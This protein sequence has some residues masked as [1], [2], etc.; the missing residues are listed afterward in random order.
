[1]K[2]QLCMRGR[3]ADIWGGNGGKRLRRAIGAGVLFLLLGAGALSVSAEVTEGRPGETLS[4]DYAVIVNTSMTDAQSTGT[5]VFDAS[6]NGTST[7]RAAAVQDTVGQDVQADALRPALRSAAYGAAYSVGAQKSIDSPYN[8]RRTYVCIGE[9]AHCYV[10]MEE[11][12]KTGYDGLKKTDSIANDMMQT[13]EGQPY[14]MLKEMAGGSLPWGKLSVMLETISNASGVYKYNAELAAIHINT[15]AAASYEYGSMGSRNALLVH[16]GQHALFRLMA[17]S[18]PY[19]P[20]TWLNE[21]ISVA[22]MDWLWGGTDS[23]GWMDSIAGN[24]DIRNGSP[25][26]YKSY[27]NST[28]Q[29][30]G[31]PY[32]FVRYLIAQTTGGYRPMQLIPHFY[33]VSANCSP[34][35]YLKNVFSEAGKAVSFSDLLTNFYTA[36]I[37][38]ES[39]GAYGFEGDS[40]V[41]Q[42]VNNYPLYMGASGT[43]HS[44]AP[45]AAIM[46]KLEDGSFTVPTDGG[47]KI[48]YMVVSGGRNVPVPEGGDGSSEHPYEID[49][50][51]DLALIGNKPGAHYK[52][53]R[54]I[55]ASGQKNLTVSYFSGVLDGDGH[56]IDGLSMPLIGRNT[57]TIQNLTIKAV[58]TGDFAGVQGAFAQVNSGLIKDCM[59]TGTVN[60]K[61]LRG[62]SSLSYAA[63]GAFAGENE[64]AGRILRCETKV[65]ITLT[66]PAESCYVGGIAGVQ[67]GTVKNCGS[68]GSI[69]VTQPNADSA[70]YVGGLAGK[71]ESMGMGGLLSCCIHTGSIQVTGENAFV[72]Q[73]CGLADRSVMNTG[74]N[75]HIVDC[76]AKKGTILAVGFTNA[77]NTEIPGDIDEKSLL[78][79][80]KLKQE[81]SYDGWNFGSEWKMGEDGPERFGASDI[82]EIGAVNTP[83][84]CYVGE[85][86]Y[87]WGRLTINEKSGAEI[88]DDMVSGFDSST[89]GVKTV[90]VNYLGKTTTFA[91]NVKK[92]GKITGFELPE[93]ALRAVKKTYSVGQCFDPSGL[94]F[95]ATIDGS[96]GHLIYSG[97]QY[98]T[99]PLTEIDESVTVSYYGASIEIPIEVTGK[100]PVSLELAAKP[101]KTVYAEGQNLDLSGLRM[102]LSYNNGEATL[103]FGADQL[104]EYGVHV[105]KKTGN[106]YTE[107]KPDQMLTSADNGAVIYVCATEAMPNSSG[108]I[109]KQIATL[110]VRQGLHVEDSVVHVVQG[111]KISEKLPGGIAMQWHNPSFLYDGTATAANGSYISQYR[112]IDTDLGQSITAEITVQVHPSSY[113]ELYLFEIPAGW[114]DDAG[115]TEDVVGIIDNERNTVVLSV[116][117]GTDVSALKIS[118]D[119][120]AGIGVT[121]PAGYGLMSEH[122]FSKPLIYELIAPDKVT[123]RKYTVTVEFYNPAEESSGGSG[124]TGGSGGGSTSGSAGGSSEPGSGGGTGGQPSGS[125]GA[126]SGSAGAG[127]GTGGGQ[128][129]GSVSTGSGG[130]G[131]GTGTGGGQPSGSGSTDGGSGSDTGGSQIPDGFSSGQAN[132]SNDPKIGTLLKQGGAYY[133]ITGG[134]RAGYTAELCCLVKKKTK[135]LKVAATV[136]ANGHDYKVTSIAARACK[137]NR[138][139]RKVTIGKYVQVI[140][141][142]AFYGCK[143]LRQITVMG[144][145]LK[146]VK[147]GAVKKI[148]PKAVVRVPKKKRAA[149][150]KLFKRKVS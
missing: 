80:E 146:K 125:G 149:Y 34:D 129:S 90:K 28:A 13:Y 81:A 42:K 65:E 150:R 59:V 136:K 85:Q 23:N 54:D 58:F 130:A 106:T 68:R 103:V 6:G 148:H 4:G 145:A 14:E 5:L 9:S 147:S 118:T 141:A 37:A 92:P 97:F 1:M 76:R 19:Q 93:S 32:L 50:F 109:A 35:V 84:E 47:G 48:R 25:L 44:L 115:L 15:P 128:P 24:T 127:T 98:D 46:V 52:L 49:D 8:G 144:T 17:Q 56:M 36:I 139:L 100:R 10:W 143:N 91:V 117:D 45:T 104:G 108:A 16:E 39:N 60:Q 79:D 2:R 62:Q 18:N 11:S 99:K 124:G 95:R 82:Q 40:I 51:A 126:G 132:V 87:Y 112:V 89:V 133:R 78:T 74:L 77:A 134:G 3:F 123:R 53:T 86:I 135:T 94:Y 70:L 75:S 107:I 120:G 71:L 73:L 83:A 140:G 122:D 57:G 138:Y 142:K 29:D 43:A 31:M 61:I 64:V 113:A 105:V 67:I 26:F 131:A 137:G 12:L 63:F 69:A 20:Y 88:T 101:A 55:T 116:P 30:Y 111:V 102:S 110:T 121:V 119:Y 41:R 66:A 21:G 96:S 27:R 22:A 114:N 72:G 33:Q 38:Q 7:V